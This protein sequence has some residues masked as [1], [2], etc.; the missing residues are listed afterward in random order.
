MTAASSTARPSE[1]NL[2][3][4][5]EAIVEGVGERTAIVFRQRRFSY[6]ELGNRSRQFARV[7]RERGVGVRRADGAVR[8]PHESQQDHVAIYATNGNEY[9]E[10]MLG[11][12]K[13]RAAPL[14]V[15]YRYV[16]DELRYVLINSSAKSIVFQSAFAPT[17]EE[18]LP[19]LPAPPVLLQIDDGTGGD[20]LSGAE[21]YEQALA[22]A[23][24]SFLEWAD[25][26]SPDD[27]Y[28]L[29]TGGTTGTPKAV[30]WRHSDIHRASLG[31]RNPL[32]RDTWPSIEALVAHAVNDHA[33][34]VVLPSSPFMHGA[35]HWTALQALNL[36][37]TVVIQDD[38]NRL[39]AADIC[40]VIDRERV[41]YL[42]VVGDT[43]CRPIA[44]EMDAGSHDLSSLRIIR[45]GGTGLSNTLKR[46]FL[47]RLPG[48]TLM[49]SMGSSEGG[50]QGVQLMR[51]DDAT[52]PTA[53]T[54]VEGSVV[55]S[56]ERDH[57]LHPGDRETGWLAKK[58]DIALGYLGDP[59][60][61][62][63]TFPTIAGDR[64]VVPGDRARWLADGTIELLG[65]DSATIN[66]G[67]EKIFAEEVEG[68]ILNHPDVQDVLVASRP[69]ERWGQEVVAIVALRANASA[70]EAELSAE[71]GLHIARYKLP[72]AWIF[73]DV[74]SRLPAGKPDRRWAA[75][76]ATSTFRGE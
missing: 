65:R 46:R 76:I 49:D 9:I 14:N 43:F 33:P 48:L 50:G 7:L 40:S 68:A 10:A 67:G 6:A 17:V 18:V 47:E 28:I 21:W 41:T 2:A 57:V 20:L 11:A 74:V 58:G 12:F 56:S 52:T 15:N 75:R 39:N 63:E 32:T 30:L 51:A 22:N 45:T 4:V 35:G 13:A 26:W 72:K 3:Q 61:T 59:K 53:F 71:A 66:S 16:A 27:L 44:Y 25:E 60:M 36:G 24:N 70:T 62:S 1:Y 69:S 64:Y 19:D 8:G 73:V 37:G 5:N 23:S 54:P 55:L 38:V 29:Y 34:H 42:Q 31:G